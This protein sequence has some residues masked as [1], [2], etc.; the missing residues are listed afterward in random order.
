MEALR[1][2]S[3]ESEP[4][5]E[6][7]AMLEVGEAWRRKLLK[8]LKEEE[9]EEEVEE[10]EGIGNE[11]NSNSFRCVSERLE[12]A[13]ELSENDKSWACFAL[14]AVLVWCVPCW[15]CGC[16]CLGIGGWQR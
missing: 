6:E 4:L 16:G 10:R 1:R 2:E 3:E 7:R 5:R 11:E 14:G 8:E 9:E 13:A 15:G 12:P